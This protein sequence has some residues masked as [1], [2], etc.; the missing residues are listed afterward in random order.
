MLRHLI[1]IYGDVGI[2]DHTT[3]ATIPIAATSLGACMIEKHLCLSRNDPIEDRAFS[4][5]PHEFAQMTKAVRMTWEAMQP[6]K[7]TPLIES[8]RELRRSLYVVQDMKAGD[9]FTEENLRSIRPFHGLPP[10]DYPSILGQKA[11]IDIERG[12][13]LRRGMIA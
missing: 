10:R 8:S 12:T 7:P 13:P 6:K 9:V 2:S 4:M 1:T 3:D 5:E 11:K